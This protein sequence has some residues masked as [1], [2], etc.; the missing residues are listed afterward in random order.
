MDKGCKNTPLSSGE[1]S[2]QVGHLFGGAGGGGEV[3]WR[4]SQP[5]LK[6]VAVS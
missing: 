5:Y 4:T 3:P 2:H 6:V 1:A